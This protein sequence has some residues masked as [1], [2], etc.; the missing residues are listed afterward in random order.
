[1]N[2]KPEEMAS[3]IYVGGVPEETTSYEL[4]NVFITFGEIKLVEIP[5]DH[6]TGK[7]YIPYYQEDLEDLHSLSTKTMKMLK[8]PSI[9]SMILNYL[10]E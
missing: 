1:M 2:E 6:N 3:T 4:K 8:L 10:E 7:I 5:L 9:T